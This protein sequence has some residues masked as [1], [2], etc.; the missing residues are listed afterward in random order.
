[1]M[2]CLMVERATVAMQAIL[3]V[4]HPALRKLSRGVP[5]GVPMDQEMSFTS[6]INY[7]FILLNIFIISFSSQF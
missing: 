6:H 7:R 1:M 4:F 3:E 2:V 5:T